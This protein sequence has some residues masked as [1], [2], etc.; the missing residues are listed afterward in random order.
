V[1]L[2][3]GGSHAREI[4]RAGTVRPHVMCRSVAE[5]MHALGDVVLGE[6]SEKAS[7]ALILM[8]GMALEM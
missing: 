2:S 3:C 4:E 6:V 1:L 7:V 8:L 5:S